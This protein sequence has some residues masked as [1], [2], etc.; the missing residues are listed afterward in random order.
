MRVL[1]IDDERSKYPNLA[2]MK[3]GAYHKSVGDTVG[4]HVSDPDIVYGSIIFESSRHQID[5]LKFYYPDAEIRLGGSGH[6]ISSELPEEVEFMRPDYSLYP[7]CDYSLGYTTRGCIR[8]C[9]FCIVRQKEGKLRRWQHPKHFHDTRF[10]KIRLYDNNILADPD[11]FFEVTDWVLERELKVEFNQGLD[12]RLMDEDVA[13]RLKQLKR[14]SNYN[15]AWDF[16]NY[17]DKVM[18]GIDMLDE[19]GFDL[20]SDLGFYVLTNYDTDHYED[21]YRMMKLKD[22]GT[23]PFIM[24]YEGGDTLTRKMARYTNRRSILRS[25]DFKDYDRLTREEKIEVEQLHHRYTR[26]AKE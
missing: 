9:G 5:G 4:F 24:M 7:D 6:D 15:F 26:E 1:L 16:I 21:Y 12:I 8:N 2:L 14:W 10:C 20:K 3:I 23:N 25:S 22:R 11:W 13:S 18:E 17:E 19:V